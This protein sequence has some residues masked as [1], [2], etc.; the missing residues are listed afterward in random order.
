MYILLED[1]LFDGESSTL[2]NPDIFFTNS[3]NIN[4]ELPSSG[5]PND[6]YKDKMKIAS[7]SSDTSTLFNDT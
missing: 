3:S 2:T 5:A 4:R 6:E 7:I 1:A